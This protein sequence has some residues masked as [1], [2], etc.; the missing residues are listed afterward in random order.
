[1]AGHPDDQT[2]ANWRG[3][4]LG[5]ATNVHLDSTHP[6]TI[7]GY[8]TNFASI[9]LDIYNVFTKGMSVQVAF[10]TDA[11]LAQL[12]G[13]ET[14]VLLQ[15]Q[16]LNC[17]VPALG[18]YVRIILATTDATG[19]S[20]AYTLAP[21]N[22]PAASPRYQSVT[23]VAANKNQSI[24]A[25]TTIIVTLSELASGP[26]W[27]FV[28]DPGSTSKFQARL[29]LVN[30]DGTEGSILDLISTVANVYRAQFVAPQEPVGIAIQNTDTVAHNFTYALVVDG[31]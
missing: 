3:P 24:P 20:I 17:F 21:S 26:G 28:F 15:D 27:W 29:V 30:Q 9:F 22:Q 2:Y 1:M 16:N 25:S 19:A 11:T 5:S 6:I 31:R 7:T 10:F 13:S 14:F 18:N 12:C 23:A 4:L 8:V